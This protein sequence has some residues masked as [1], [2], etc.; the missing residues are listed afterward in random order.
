MSFAPIARPLPA[1][2]QLPAVQTAPAERRNAW[3]APT[4]RWSVAT[5]G[6]TAYSTSRNPWK[7]GVRISLAPKGRRNPAST[8]ANVPPP[9]RGGIQNDDLFPQVA[10]VRQGELAPPVTTTRRPC[11]ANTCLGLLCLFALTACAFAPTARADD[12]RSTLVE[13]QSHFEAARFDQALKL[14]EKANATEPGHAAIEYNLALCHLRLGDGDKAAQQFETL[15]SRAG[16]SAAL[17][18]DAFYNV[19]LIRARAAREQ[20]QGLLAPATQPTDRKP[21][22]D[23]PENIPKLEAIAGDLLRA[24]AAFRQSTASGADADAEHNIRAA[25]ITRRDVLGLLRRA[26]E[27][28]QKDDIL[29]DPRAYLESLILEQG[30]QVAVGRLLLLDP[31]ADAAQLRQARRAGLRAQRKLMETTGTLADNLAQFREQQKDPRPPAPASAPSTQPAEETPREKAYH[32]AAK[33]LTKAVEAQRTACA[34]LLDNE[35]RPAYDRQTAAREEMTVALYMFPLDPA[36]VLVKARGRQTELRELVSNLK[37]APDWLRDPLLPEVSLP[38]DAQ[39]DADQTPIHYAQKQIGIV[40][41]RLHRQCEYVATTTQPA[42]EPQAPQQPKEPLLDPE[43]NRKLADIL[44]PAEELQKQCLAA[45]VAQHRKPALAAQ[46]ELI[47]LIDAALDVL[48]KTLEQKVTEL[49]IRQNQLN[50]DVQAEAGTPS[51]APGGSAAAALDEVRKW[52][53]RFKSALL[54]GQPAKVAESLSARQKTLRSDTDAVN[55]EVRKNV[56]SGATA[57][58]GSSATSQP[59]EL[60][61]F[62][63]AAKHLTEAGNHMDSA[64]KGFDQAVVENSL[65]PLQ[66]DGPV[67]VPQAKALEE[68]LKALLALQP[69]STQP[70]EDQDDQRQQQQQQRQPTRDEDQQRELERLDRERER[71]ERELYQRRP[72][73]VIKDW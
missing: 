25:R 20:L 3:T 57:Q 35:L 38:K 65:K 9:L 23:D 47:K 70:S 29:K 52:A 62:I 63:E 13:A 24:I 36:Q 4:G 26:K 67:Q 41:A 66:P 72:R 1:A 27:T 37:A 7:S 71:A 32:A 51:N 60:K 14:Y 40:L 59:A 8:P 2:C 68:L 45:I 15:A 34:F 21:S 69:P 19:G 44:Q 6:A 16:I 55:E 58:P 49:I 39:W 30:R 28:K 10:L 73:T 12:L 48:P 33:Q 43:L 5:G 18:R 64:L 22:A 54:R 61:G 56:P 42:E 11:G 46:D 31:P 53:T 17:Q 50:A